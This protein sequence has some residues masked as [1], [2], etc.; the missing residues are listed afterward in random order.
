ML[1]GQKVSVSSSPILVVDALG[2]TAKI[3]AAGEDELPMLGR[4]LERQYHRFKAKVPHRFM[5]VSRKRVWGSNDFQTFRLNDMFIVYSD[6]GGSE[7]SFRI[8][9]ASSLLYQTMLME[10]FV[11]RGGLGVGALLKRS[12]LLVGAGF[13]DAY[14]ASEK[15]DERTRHI[16]AIQVSPAFMRSIPNTEKAYPLLCFYK[17]AFFVHPWYLTDPEIGEFNADRII[18]CLREGGANAEKLAATTHF[19]REFQDYDA[20]LASDPPQ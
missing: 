2:F 10:R 15:R 13:V 16:C 4:T 9:V 3:L 12:D 8:L 19:L 20:A 5:I 11:P 17:N 1:F 6:K 7:N 14:T 18:G